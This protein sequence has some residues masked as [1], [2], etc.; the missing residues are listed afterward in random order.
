MNRATSHLR[1]LAERLVAYE[2]RANKSGPAFSRGEF[3]I[4]EKLRPDLVTLVGRAGYH[5]L[6]S[7]ALALAGAEAAWLRIVQVKTDGTL[8]GPENLMPGDPKQVLEGCVVLVAQLLGLLVAF[9][10]ENLTLRLVREVW[11]KIPLN[12][13]DFGSGGKNE[14]NK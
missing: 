14:K 9:I 7:R 5:A 8:E 3:P 11:P 6:I 10:G 2:T 12:G 4:C 1:G 13:L